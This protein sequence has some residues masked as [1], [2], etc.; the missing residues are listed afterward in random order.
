[1]KVGDLS[2]LSVQVELY[3]RALAADQPLLALAALSG[4]F[5]SAQG[6]HFDRIRATF[7]DGSSLELELAEPTLD[8]GTGAWTSVPTMHSEAALESVALLQDRTL[9]QGNVR[10][11]LLLSNIQTSSPISLDVAVTTRAMPGG[12]VAA[13]LLV[14]AS[15]AIAAGTPITLAYLVTA[16]VP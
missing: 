6:Y 7:S 12:N 8:W 2:R 16:T 14:D 1:L 5:S 3:P 11:D 9:A 4:W 10:P 13:N 15:A